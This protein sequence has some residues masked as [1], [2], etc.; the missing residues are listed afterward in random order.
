MSA[1]RA[2]IREDRSFS[3]AATCRKEGN[4]RGGRTRGSCGDA[5]LEPLHFLYSFP[6]SWQS[7]VGPTLSSI[8][9]ARKLST[10]AGVVEAFVG[11][12][13]ETQRPV[14]VKRLAGPWAQVEGFSD[15]FVPAA[16]TMT[17][18]SGLPNILEVGTSG[19]TTWL[20]QELVEGES[21]RHVMNA[22]AQRASFIAPNEG[23]AVVGRIASL[24]ASLHSQPEPV[25]HGDLCT[26]TVLLTPEGAVQLIDAGVANAAGT[27]ATFGPARAETYSVAPEQ[28]AGENTRATDLFRLGL[29]LYE[30]SLGRPLFFAAEPMQA[31]VQ[32]QRFTGLQRAALKQI[33]DPYLT[34]LVSMLSPDPS[35]RPSAVEVDDA[36]SQAAAKAGWKP[37]DQDI[38][39]LFAR[40]CPDRVP[41]SAP[42]GGA[43]QELV[44]TPLFTRNGA[45][46]LNTPSSTPS[47]RAT[48]PPA[49]VRAMTPPPAGPS[50]TP[51]GA[52][53]ARIA[54]RK[55]SMSELA[56]VKAAELPE[57]PRNAPELV[58]DPNAPKDAKVGE[59]L[60]ERGLLTK[61]QLAEA[62]EQV[63]IYGGTLADALTSLGYADEDLIVTTLA[64]ATRTP[65]MTSKKL[66]DMPPAPEALKLV[67]FE[68]ARTLDVVPLMIKGTTQLMIAMKDPLDTKA[69]DALKAATGFKSIVAVRGGERAI[70]RTRNRFYTGTEDDTPDWVERSAAEKAQWER[71]VAAA[72]PPDA[73]VVGTLVNDTPS[74][75][76]SAP[77][78]GAA[79]PPADGALSDAA[80]RLVDAMLTTHGDRGRMAQQLIALCSGLAKRLG[81]DAAQLPK[82]RFAATALVVANFVDGRPV[83]DVPTAASLTSVL[84]PAWNELEALVSPLLDWPTSMPDDAAAQGVVLAF[85]FAAHAG[86]PHPRGSQLGG[87]IASF[88]T[89]F[90]VAQPFLEALLHEL[91]S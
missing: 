82:V 50:V 64:E 52:V 7:G 33:P 55:M 76:L 60:L 75:D 29:V 68:L 47:T 15:R 5:P 84:G 62:R 90:R 4:L 81:A 13:L 74:F 36:L 77:L 30:L 35:E 88:K 12:Q 38:G 23:L 11:V 53:V 85:A 91:G 70:R 43:M 57:A 20:V 37:P 61:A 87:A 65:A 21:L 71:N 22:L 54:T 78:A 58:E 40:A 27:S 2:D 14:V 39:K 6:P 34:L 86:Q 41:L 44:L 18:A 51:P 10:A 79:I 26:S 46:R 1:Q 72:E 42:S 49:N 67:P 56:A 48:T 19:D 32:C 69:I 83:Y 8:R 59:V 66:A 63:N 28:L 31:L 45:A 73:P 3:A 9:I 80:M 16:R 24:L 17:S 25:V 89:R